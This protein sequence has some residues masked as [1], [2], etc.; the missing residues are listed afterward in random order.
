[1]NLYEVLTKDGRHVHVFAQDHEISDGDLTL[2]YTQAGVYSDI[3]PEG[4]WTRFAVDGEEQT[5]D[6]IDELD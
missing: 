6:N 3:F 5:V 4:Y 1:M 2:Y